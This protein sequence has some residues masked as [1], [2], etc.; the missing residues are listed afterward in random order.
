[1]KA[2]EKAYALGAAVLGGLGLLAFF[3]RLQP[4]NLV[5][6][7]LSSLRAPSG[8][9]PIWPGAPV[10]PEARIAFQVLSVEGENVTGTPVGIV[11]GGQVTRASF[12]PLTVPILFRKD[13]IIRKLPA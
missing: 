12:G 8:T 13:D 11:Q 5:E 3:G 7:Q 6:V 1:M 10:N 9:G 2:R 4:G